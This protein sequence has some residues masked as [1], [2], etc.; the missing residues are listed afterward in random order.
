MMFSSSGG[1][2]KPPPQV[3]VPPPRFRA[4]TDVGWRETEAGDGASR[5]V[6]GGSKKE[7]L[8]E[9]RLQDGML[10]CTLEIGLDRSEY[11]IIVILLSSKS[12]SI[13]H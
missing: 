5:C 4:L 8:G 13:C 11:V 9:G 1:G 6:P 2:K 7:A 12:H 10:T 3:S